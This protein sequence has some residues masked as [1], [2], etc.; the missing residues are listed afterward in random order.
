[1]EVIQRI[2]AKVNNSLVCFATTRFTFLHWHSIMHGLITPVLIPGLLCTT[3]LFRDQLNALRDLAMRDPVVNAPEVADTLSHESVEAMAAAALMATKGTVVAIG[4]SMGGY[5]ALEMARLSPDRVK[6]LILLS[7][8]YKAD[9]AKKRAQRMA[10]IKIAESDKFCGVT[11]HLL[12]SF[13]SP[14]ALADEALVARVLK[15]VQDVGRDVFISQ[16]TAIL[17]R[18]DH[19]DTLAAY[20]GEIMILCG[21]LDELTPPE[22]SREMAAMATRADLRLLPEIGHLSSLEAP[23]A[24]NNAVI[25]LLRRVCE[26]VVVCPYR[27]SSASTS[28]A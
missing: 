6:G 1:M 13:L 3:E 7:T 10:T 9:T 19:S 11:R 21:L 22:W 16:Q 4:L 12:G 23:Q 2:A 15:M 17:N 27:S 28:S 18:R 24:V 25:E 5:V 14:E 8:G 26:R 20:K